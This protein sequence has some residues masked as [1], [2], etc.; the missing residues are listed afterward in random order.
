MGDAEDDGK[1]EEGR[2][3]WLALDAR[4][5]RTSFRLMLSQSIFLQKM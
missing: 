1:G 5:S 4:D 3:I 2:R